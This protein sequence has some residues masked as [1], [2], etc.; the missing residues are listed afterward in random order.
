MSLS[1][2][3]TVFVLIV[4]VILVSPLLMAWNDATH[5]A[6]ARAAGLENIAYL[7]IAADT[8]KVKAGD[9]EGPNHY[10]NADKGTLITPDIVMGQIRLYDKAGD[11][12]GHLYGAIMASLNLC[13]LTNADKKTIRYPF[14]YLMHY[15]GDL[16]MPLHNTVYNDFNKIHHGINDRVVEGSEDEAMETKIARISGE[17]KKRMRTLPPLTLS[18]DITRFY[19]EVA[20]QISIVANRASELGYAMQEAVPQ[21]TVMSQDEAYL[22]LAQS[23]RLLKAIAEAIKMK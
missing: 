18:T 3:Y 9:S 10:V 6:I 4:L 15:I 22:Q 19:R 12:N 21:R 20:A 16:S 5:M 2:R 14:G 1:S 7:A 13:L 17:I 23:A 11:P 8:A